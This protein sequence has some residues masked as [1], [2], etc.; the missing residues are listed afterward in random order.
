VTDVW[1]C[2][3]TAQA[4]IGLQGALSVFVDALPISCFGE[5]DASA[6]LTPL[7]G[8][9]PYAF[10]WSNGSVQAQ[11][12]NLPPGQYAVTMTD[13]FGCTATHAFHFVAPDSLQVV[14]ATVKATGAMVSDGQASLSAVSGGTVPY[15]YNWSTGATTTEIENL[16]PGTYNVTVTDARDCQKVLV[17]VV[18]YITRTDEATTLPTITLYPNPVESNLFVRLP[19][20]AD[21]L[22]VLDAMGKSMLEGIP[23]DGGQWISVSGLPNGFYFVQASFQGGIV[24]V[25]HFIKR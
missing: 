3:T 17:L 1:G 22:V 19:E 18:D 13:Y 9:I 6:G 12:N 4:S 15:T 24:G 8:L 21:R 14:G 20:G 2:T 11:L 5:M 23:Q 25:E 10:Q 7:N 16:L